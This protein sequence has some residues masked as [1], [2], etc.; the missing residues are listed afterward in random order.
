MSDHSPE[1]RVGDSVELI[2]G[3]GRLTGLTG[4]IRKLF[5]GRDGWYAQVWFPAEGEMPGRLLLIK[6]VGPRSSATP[7]AEGGGNAA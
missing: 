1:Q 3:D 4:T 2:D 6:V 7:P 5:R